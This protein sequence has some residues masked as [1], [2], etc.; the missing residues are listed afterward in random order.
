[1]EIRSAIGVA[2]RATLLLVLTW[3]LVAVASPSPD[4]F[5]IGLVWLGG[6]ALILAAGPGRRQVL[7]W[8]GTGRLHRAS[9]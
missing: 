6:I 2:A 4:P 9:R 7:S 8:V 1:M 3:A 5:L